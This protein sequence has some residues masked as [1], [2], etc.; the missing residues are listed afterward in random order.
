MVNNPI[1]IGINENSGIVGVGEG[2]AVGVGDGVG[3]GLAVG[4]IA[5]GDDEGVGL[6]VGGDCGGVRVKRKT[7]K[8]TALRH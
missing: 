3:L 8:N 6:E 5:C 1:M 2:V 7:K 4:V